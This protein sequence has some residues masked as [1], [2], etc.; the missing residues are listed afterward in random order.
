ME[1]TDINISALEN[2]DIDK[3]LKQT[4]KEKIEKL[5]EIEL[6]AYLE[7]NPGIKNGKYKRDLKTKYGEIKQ[8]NIPRDRD[9]NFHTQVIE[10]YNRSIGMEDLIVSMYSNGIS[11]LPHLISDSF[12]V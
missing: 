11:D 5:M 2:V 4:I 6:N 9:S 8:L 10:P 1:N 3:I 7:E 12:L